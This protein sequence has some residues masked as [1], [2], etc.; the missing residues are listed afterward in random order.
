MPRVRRAAVRGGR[1]RAGCRRDARRGAGSGERR[2]AAEQADAHAVRADTEARSAD[3]R[4]LTAERALAD[5]IAGHDGLAALADEAAGAEAAAARAEAGLAERRAERKTLEAA[6]RHAREQVIEARGARQAAAGAVEAA[7]RA[8]SGIETRK[9]R[10]AETLIAYFGDPIPDD[11]G[12]AGRRSPAYT[13]TPQWW[14]NRAKIA[15]SAMRAQLLA[16]ARLGKTKDNGQADE[17]LAVDLALHPSGSL[18]AGYSFVSEPGRENSCRRWGP[19]RPSAPFCPLRTGLS[20]AR[21]V[22]TAFRSGR[23]QSLRYH[24]LSFPDAGGHIRQDQG[25]SG[26]QP[27][28]LAG[29]E[30]VH[31]GDIAGTAAQS[32]HQ[33]HC[34]GAAAAADAIISAQPAARSESRWT[35]REGWTCALE[36]NLGSPARLLLMT[37][38]CGSRLGFGFLDG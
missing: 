30:I 14:A 6:E 5:A 37:V 7:A 35:G 18:R 3:E 36:E 38:S 34:A 9:V 28:D 12:G 15:R 19:G 4:A 16:V 29:L 32:F 27:N 13:V 26:S 24:R 22:L 2:W 31:N 23:G 33:H 1:R 25:I 17:A 20:F 10:A 11:A 8:L 21:L